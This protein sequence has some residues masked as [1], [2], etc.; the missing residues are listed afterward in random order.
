M[1]GCSLFS[2]AQFGF[3]ESEQ[4]DDQLLNLSIRLGPLPDDLYKLWDNSSLYF[5][6]E[7]VPYNFRLGGASGDKE[8]FMFETETLEEMFDKAKVDMSD[9]EAKMVKALLRRILQYDTAMRPSAGEILGDTWF[10]Q[11]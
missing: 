10:T 8:P 7:R 6:P 3:N 5:T 4:D 9:E 2:P 11:S 1:T